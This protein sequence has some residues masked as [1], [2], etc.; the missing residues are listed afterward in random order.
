MK[1]TIPT[2]FSEGDFYLK[3][4]KSMF[5]LK[6]EEQCNGSCN[7]CLAIKKYLDAYE[8]FLFKKNFQTENYHVL[9]RMINQKDSKFNQFSEKIFEV[10]C[11]A[12]ESKREKE[13]FFLFAEEM[14]DVLKIVL[15]IR[16]YI[17]N[18]VGYKKEFFADYHEL[19]IMDI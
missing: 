11:F 2:L 16:S 6:K 10:K 1:P 18:K 12:E 15:D 14:N 8:K 13:K 19:S 9:L 3:E 4:A 5:F 17:A 7:S